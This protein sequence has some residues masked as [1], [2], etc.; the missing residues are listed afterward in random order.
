MAREIKSQNNDDNE[1]EHGRKKEMTEG[2]G[3][4]EAAGMKQQSFIIST[5]VKG[6]DSQHH[7]KQP[8]HC[9]YEE[10]FLM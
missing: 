10:K 9:F 1:T 8:L 7:S 2:K 3:G 5:L 6:K 4:G